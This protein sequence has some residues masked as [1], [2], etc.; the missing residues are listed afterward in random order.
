MR[1]EEELIQQVVYTM[2]I[3]RCVDQWLR[4]TCP[5]TQEWR[6]ARRGQGMLQEQWEGV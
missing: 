6:C 3:P 1:N 4:N 2:P 5:H